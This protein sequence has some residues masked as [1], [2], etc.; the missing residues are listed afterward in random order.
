MTVKEVREAA[1][2]VA[3]YIMVCENELG[4]SKHKKAKPISISEHE[5]IKRLINKLNN[6]ENYVNQSVFGSDSNGLPEL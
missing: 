6:C 5:A 2:L 4:E 3:N 1:K